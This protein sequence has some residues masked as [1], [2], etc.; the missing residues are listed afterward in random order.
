MFIFTLVNVSEE[1][2]LIWVPFPNSGE[3]TLAHFLG[4]RGFSNHSKHNDIENLS[5]GELN[6]SFSHKILSEYENFDVICSVDNPYRLIVN[7]YKK[8]SRMNWSLKSNTKVI[9]SRNFNEWIHPI[10]FDDISQID[11][12]DKSHFFL[13]PFIEPENV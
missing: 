5:L 11:R 10:I 4:K 1:H 6:I 13:F 8:F 12:L 2:K 7:Q 3:R 9:L